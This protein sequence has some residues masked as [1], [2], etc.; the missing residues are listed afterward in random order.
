MRTVMAL[1]FPGTD[2]VFLALHAGYSRPGGHVA[3]VAGNV[4]V[5]G[6]VC[7]SQTVWLHTTTH[8][9]L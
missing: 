9:G 7:C 8:R 4:S 3:D 2:G 1:L 5:C 6:L